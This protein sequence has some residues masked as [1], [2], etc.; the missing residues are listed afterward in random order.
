MSSNM[1]KAHF[2]TTS[3]ARSRLLY[4]R[5]EFY[6]HLIFD[7][8]KSIG[9][10]SVSV[11][12]TKVMPLDAR[13]VTCYEGALLN[14]LS[15]ADFSNPITTPWR[16]I[17]AKGEK[18]PVKVNFSPDL[19]L[20]SAGTAYA[21]LAPHMKSMLLEYTGQGDSAE[22]LK[23]EPGQE[24]SFIG[25]FGTHRCEGRLLLAFQDVQGG[26]IEQQEARIPANVEGGKVLAKYA[27]T[28]ITALAPE[29]AVSATLQIHATK[30][31]EAKDAFLFLTRLWFGRLSK[32]NL[33]E[34][35]P[36][37]TDLVGVDFP[38]F[39]RYKLATV[40][41]PLDCLDG[42]SH[43]L[44]VIDTGRGVEFP[45]SPVIIEESLKVTGEIS[46]ISDGV[47][48][49]RIIF[50][51]ASDRPLAVQLL[52][53]GEPTTVA[54]ASREGSNWR[55][56]LAIP[57]Q[58]CDGRPHVFALRLQE[59]GQI[60]DR[61]PALSP[62]LIT[63][64]DAIQTYAG[65]PIDASLSPVARSRYKTVL[66]NL[67][68]HRLDAEKIYLLH[69]E[70]LAG[71]KKRA[72]YRP[73]K[74]PSTDKPLVSV[75]VPVHN[76]FEMTYVGLCALALAYN[77]AEFEVIVVDDGSADE[78]LGIRK[79]V[80]GIT[81]VRHETAVGF[82]RACNAGARVARG[83]Y[84]VFLNNDTEP[85][86]RWLDEMLYFFTNFDDIGLVG[87]KLLYPDGSLQEAGGIV[88]NSGNPWNYG[89][90]ANPAAPSYSYSRQAD[91]LSGAAIMVPRKVWKAVGGFSDE[92]A[93]AYFEDTDLA[94]KVREHGLKTVYAA[95]SLV[96]HY[97]GVT[98]GTSVTSGA[99]RFQEVNRPKFK[100]RWSRAYRDN[101]QEG[102]GVDLVKDR[103]IRFRALM[104]DF[105][106]P[107]IDFDAG[108]YAA[109][110]EIRALQALGFKVVF[111][112]TNYAYMGRHT[113]TLQRIGV[114]VLYAPFAN[115]ID[116]VL[117]ERGPEFDLVYVT[118][119]QVAGQIADAVRR[120]APRAKFMINLADLHFL[121]EIRSSLERSDRQALKQA[122]ET[123][124]AELA[125]LRLADLVLSYS[126]I[127]E[128]VI[129]S[130]NLDSTRTARL[131]WIAKSTPTTPP[132]SARRNISF[133]GGFRHFPN[134]E[135]V[136][137]F[138]ER[139]INRLAVEM[140]DVRFEIYGSA[141]S[142]ENKKKWQR[143]NV[144]VRGKVDTVDEVFDSTRVFVV[145]LLSGAGVKGKLFDCL[146]YGVPSVVSP[147]AAEGIGV[148]DGMETLIASTPDEW[149]TKI[150]LLYSDPDRWERMSKAAKAFI[151]EHHSFAGGVEIMRRALEKVSLFCEPDPACMV[152][153]RCRP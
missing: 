124:D 23:I 147:V 107:R 61:M 87:A 38:D 121:R 123:R 42:T 15:N 94:F 144:L 95:M 73:L 139:I 40:P 129:M 105:E 14:H 8:G 133:L 59:T 48:R 77:E 132:F 52:V 17:T 34:W 43:R 18:T 26:T 21:R 117:A 63:P 143:G 99:K 64:F 138:I 62:T 140:P 3:S 93:P 122:L 142:E 5:G 36:S 9:D 31:V 72:E 37:L 51:K 32:S 106:V 135:A 49:G 30:L 69:S 71:P 16:V 115:S 114:E 136:D 113:E 76:K 83:E 78:T 45:G 33:P 66:D 81:L 102:V 141:I 10:F 12:D 151:D 145:P 6:F 148:R 47:V 65:M 50:G 4:R 24:Y 29:G 53:D 137:F 110:Q 109:I 127:E 20:Q 101:G 92:F 41:I 97:E 128:A 116:S 55:I 11:D 22:R 46:G 1:L 75:V 150:K 19:T 74:F 25:H 35:V 146:S 85:T 103:G 89:R 27:R 7:S 118:R 100:R 57:A 152:V 84:L 111:I 56:S 58:L 96:Y 130:H 112:P 28:A 90:G 98:S 54:L 126:T 39:E 60:L 119:Y 149:V 80:S 134:V 67:A 131:P 79:I 13:I 88:W 44:K 104:V 68:S 70:L 120:H 125:V 82:V 91:Y 108:S 153:K 86:S 2:E